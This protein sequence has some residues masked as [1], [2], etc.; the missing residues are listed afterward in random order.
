MVRRWRSASCF[1]NWSYP[2]SQTVNFASLRCA[3][4]TQMT[5]RMRAEAAALLTA[6][7]CVALLALPASAQDVFTVSGVSV[8]ERAGT[9]SEAQA[10]AFRSGQN[11]AA[12]EL[13]ERLTLPEDRIDAGL[14][15]LPS[16]AVQ[17]M[18]A[19]LQVFDE[20]RSSNRYIATMAA[21]H[22]GVVLRGFRR[23][24]AFSGSIR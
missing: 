13:L 23:F 10:A 18:I 15:A 9:T 2:P 7:L 11:A 19:G 22:F 6:I 21:S 8:D 14:M 4:M 12:R 3:I 20:R 17:E 16:D 24:H 1:S 5:N